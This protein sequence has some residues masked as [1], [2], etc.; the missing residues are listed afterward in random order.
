MS[1]LAGKY[2]EVI[3]VINADA[4]FAFKSKSWLINVKLLELLCILRTSDFDWLF[5][6]IESLRK[7]VSGLPEKPGRVTHLLSLIKTFVSE[8]GSPLGM[9]EKILQLEREHPWHPLGIE[10]INYADILLEVSNETAVPVH[11][12][13]LFSDML[14]RC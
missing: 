4:A 8:R 14:E 10:V 1:F 6:K 13:K 3:K 2:R 11:Q 9:K 7:V 5:Y 12:P